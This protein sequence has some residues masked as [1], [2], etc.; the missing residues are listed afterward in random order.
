M[1]DPFLYLVFSEWC[2]TNLPDKSKIVESI[3]ASHLARKFRIGYWKNG[4]EVD[5]VL[6][7]KHVGFEVKWS[8]KVEFSKR[9][10]GKFKDIVYLT[11]DEFNDSPL[12]VP[13][14]IFLSCLEL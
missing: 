7:D 12:A 13:V 3:V 11:M 10:I 4:S 5:V 2:L 1:I 9:S 6:L 14:S 8:K